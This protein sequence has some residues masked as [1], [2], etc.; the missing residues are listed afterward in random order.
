MGLTVLIFTFLL[1][2]TQAFL[3]NSNSVY[4]IM[5]PVLAIVEAVGIFFLRPKFYE[6]ILLLTVGVCLLGFNVWAEFGAGRSAIGGIFAGMSITVIGGIALLRKRVGSYRGSSRNEAQEVVMPLSDKPVITRRRSGMEVFQG[7]MRRIKRERNIETRTRELDALLV[8]GIPEKYALAL[9]LSSTNERELLV[10][11]FLESGAEAGEIV[12]HVTAEAANS[13]VLA[14]E[15]PSNFYLLVCNPQ[16]DT[17]VHD[18]PNL[19]K[20]KGVENLTEIDITLT[21]AFRMLTPSAAVRRRICID[22]ISDVLLQHHAVTT[23][24]WMSGLLPTLKSMSF[25]ILAVIDPGM[26]PA[27]ETKAVLGLFDEEIS[28]Q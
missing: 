20:L 18:A 6:S 25:A 22:I 4:N 11:K 15:H 21:K 28:I 24:R 27:E 17:I 9:A 12:F 16:A 26:H 23:R 10:N 13:K 8:S 14:E 3:A 7:A 1:F 19:F 5:F 2:L